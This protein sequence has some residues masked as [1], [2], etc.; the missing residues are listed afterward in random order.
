MKITLP[1]LRQRGEDILMLFTRFADQF[2]EEYGCDAPAVTAQEAAQLLQAPW[3]GNSAP[4]DQHRRTRGA[5][6][7]PRLGHDRVAAD[8]RP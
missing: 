1:P 5:A 7:A 3:P 4:A 6:I 2:A 8:E